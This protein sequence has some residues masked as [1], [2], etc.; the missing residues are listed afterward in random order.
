VAISL[1]RIKFLFIFFILVS[2]KASFADGQKSTILETPA[3]IFI[4]TGSL[5]VSI[6]K[7]E[8]LGGQIS[9]EGAKGNLLKVFPCFEFG[10]N[11]TDG[12]AIDSGG[13]NNGYRMSLG[14]AGKAG[15]KEGQGLIEVEL[16][17]PEA[18]QYY[19]PRRLSGKIPAKDAF[20][21]T[22]NV[23]IHK[24]IPRIDIIARQEIKEDL[25]THVGFFQQFYFQ[26]F[27]QILFGTALQALRI[28]PNPWEKLRFISKGPQ[29]KIRLM[30]SS[31]DEKPPFK[32]LKAAESFAD[33][34]V[35]LS[36]NKDYAVL[37]YSPSWQRYASL[38]LNRVIIPDSSILFHGEKGLEYGRV[39]SIIK[40]TTLGAGK[41][42]LMLEKGQYISEIKILFLPYTEDEAIYLRAGHNLAAKSGQPGE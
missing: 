37:V 3:E 36:K 8:L 2:G 22:L 41:E 38:G 11:S 27:G 4:D 6:W 32:L 20:C 18:V 24:D 40:D 39:V 7:K 33:F 10:A 23:I 12:S 35:M 1:M 13:R 26:P 14:K 42:V 28:N 9:I 19:R 5:K 16:S 34:W 31:Y 29:G 17:F 21:A 15:V 25:F 30:E